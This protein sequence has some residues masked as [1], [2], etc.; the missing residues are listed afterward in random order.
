MPL[1]LKQMGLQIKKISGIEWDS[2][3]NDISRT[4][5]DQ[6]HDSLPQDLSSVKKQHIQDYIHKHGCPDLFAWSTPCQGLSRANRQG[7]GL[8]DD[9]SK[10]FLD[11]M[12]V[13]QWLQEHNPKIM[14]K[15]MIKS[16]PLFDSQ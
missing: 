3:S 11:A 14:F 6:D 2:L 10:L 4:H 1:A 12:Q 8:E 15:L 16:M 7:K 9:R 13:L 5:H